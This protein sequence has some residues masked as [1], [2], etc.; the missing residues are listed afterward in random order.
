[1][2]S[3]VTKGIEVSVSSVFEPGFSK[4]EEG[5]YVFSYEVKIINEGNVDVQLLRRFWN[6]MD[7][8]GS[9]HIV[10]GDGVVGQQPIL[11]PGKSHEYQSGTYFKTAIGKMDGY[12]TFKNL[13]T[14]EEFDA[15]IPQFHMVAPFVLN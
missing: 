9:N 12:Y 4:P 5:H 15:D 13:E 3:A 8:D 10:E 14:G 7:S 6:V 1:M 11:K 2:V